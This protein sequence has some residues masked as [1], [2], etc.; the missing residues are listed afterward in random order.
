MELTDDEITRIIGRNIRDRRRIAGLSQQAIGD[1][2]G[3]SFQ[4]VQK[5][6][7]AANRISP[8]FLVRLAA[9]FACEIADFFAGIDKPAAPIETENK[10]RMPEHRLVKAYRT[11][12]DQRIKRAALS[13]FE[14]LGRS[15]T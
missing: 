2:L 13:L 11:I 15:D 3:V 12:E 4:Q 1:A 9:L 8:A 14:A 5:Y 10:D 7:N 6:E